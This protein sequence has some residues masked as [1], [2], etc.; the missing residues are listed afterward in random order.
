MLVQ[1]FRAEQTTS[2]ATWRHGG[3]LNGGRAEWL[4]GAC[5]LLPD[6]LMQCMLLPGRNRIPH[7][8]FDNLSTLI[9]VL[10]L[11]TLMLA[12]SRS[13]ITR[14]APAAMASSLLLRLESTISHDSL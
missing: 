12:P 13:S 7:L 11:Y 5:C 4:V 14:G 6:R 9:S 10:H 2:A 1:R 8:P 3:V